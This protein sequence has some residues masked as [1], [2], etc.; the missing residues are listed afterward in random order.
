[1]GRLKW[2][3]DLH[4]QHPFKT[5]YVITMSIIEIFLF[6]YPIQITADIIQ[7]VID[8]GGFE[9][10]KGDL[11]FLFFFALFQASLF[12]TINFVNETLAHRVTTDMTFELYKSLQYKS[13]SYHDD[14]DVGQIM[15]RAT[16]DTRN[17]N[18]ALSPGIVRTLSLLTTWCIAIY[19][20]Y[21]IHWMLLLFT[22]LSFVIYILSLGI[23]GKGLLQLSRQTLVDYAEV[24]ET[25]ANALSGIR[26][27]K[28]YTAEEWSA[29]LF[30]QSVDK[31]ITSKI[32]EGEKGAWFYPALVAT[33]YTAG[34]IGMSLYYAYQGII[35]FREVVLVAGII[36]FLRGISAQVQWQSRM[37]ISA[38]AASKRVYSLIHEEDLDQFDDGSIQ[39]T[40][41]PATI[42]FEGVSFR[43]KE[44]LPFVLKDISFQMDEN[45]TIAIVGPPGSG[46]STLTK[47][48]QRLYKPTHGEIFIGNHS[49]NDYSNKSLREHLSTVEQDVFLFNN[50][51][52]HNIKFGRPTATYEEIVEVAK[53]A[54][55]HNFISNFPDK[56]QNIVGEGGVKLSGG[57][58][59]R[60]SIARALLVNP[61]ILLMDDGASALDARTEANIQRAISEILKTRTTLITTHRLA[62]I[63]KADIV[64]ILEKGEMLG[65]GTHEEL[66]KSN[67]YY[68]RLFEK[69]Y[70]LP[71][72][73]AGD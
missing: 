34:V 4:L 35:S 28:S 14:K 30:N 2:I 54:E 29:N 11:I 19:L 45:Q 71:P 57:Q 62:I 59:Q 1:V 10:A 53:L 32:K 21:R 7:E 60:I 18:N 12:F 33:I 73:I 49:I 63:A 44:N 26:E 9:E 37:I 13:L 20:T 31:H 5:F 56:Y 66:I 48:I 72:L 50:T 22:I 46:K 65:I 68:R 36:S 67:R 15:A 8:G 55:A 17:I 23:Y 25:S 42:R 6:L 3:V 52:L 40:G 43:Y 61:S 70:E 47:L 16:G 69:H 41:K 58:A 64:I 51:I 24:S 27:L 38:V 39:F